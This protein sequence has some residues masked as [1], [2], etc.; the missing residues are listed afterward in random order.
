MSSPT[1]ISQDPRFKLARSLLSSDDASGKSGP[2][3]AI[4]IFAT[5]LEECRKRFGETSLDAALCQY[6]YGNALF[7]A[8]LRTSPLDGDDF[9]EDTKPA[10]GESKADE[11]AG[12]K[13]KNQPNESE[14]TT[15]GSTSCKTL[16]RERLKSDE[17]TSVEN[18]RADEDLIDHTESRDKDEDDVD[19][20]LEMMETSFAIFESHVSNDHGKLGETNNSNI[21]EQWVSGQLPR[22]LVG[23]ADVHSFRE[24][25]GNAVDAYCRALPYRE[26]AWDEMKKSKKQEDLL[27]V[28]H[29]KCQRHLVE[30][31]AL[32]AET[33]LNC[34]NG[35]DVICYYD[36]E[37]GGEDNDDQKLP[38]KS[39]HESIEEEVSSSVL[40]KAEERVNFARSHY[41][42]AREGL[43]EI[44]YR[45]GKMAA[46]RKELGDEKEDICYLV[47][48][49]VGLANGLTDAENKSES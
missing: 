36:E 13:R 38:A 40:V 41:E 15:Q 35:E 12:K 44:V 46:A 43:E 33:L 27:T 14:E 22:I 17:E 31:Y 49:L 25:Y 28:E 5:L 39:L 21:S 45:M 4:D 29:L 37:K 1:K 19:L 18:G 30:T 16:K 2:E 23:I 34:P 10:A 8:F 20:A 11:A 42:M 7:R 48:M 32:I 24:N 47:T 6:E 26:K 9:V 3:A